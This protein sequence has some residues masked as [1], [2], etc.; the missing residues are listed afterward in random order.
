MEQPEIF[1]STLPLI[2]LSAFLDFSVPIIN[3]AIFI[4]SLQCY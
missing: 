3:A 2:L 4:L 1:S